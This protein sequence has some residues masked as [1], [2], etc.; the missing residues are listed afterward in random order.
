[1]KLIWKL[2][3]LLG[4]LAGFFYLAHKG[5]GRAYENT[6]HRYVVMDESHSNED[7]AE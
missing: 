7:V 1:M 3:S 5:I 6:I 4:A 2:L